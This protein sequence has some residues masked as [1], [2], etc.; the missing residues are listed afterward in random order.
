[1]VEVGGIGTLDQSLVAVS[2]GGTVSFIGVIT[3]TKGEVSMGIA[4]RKAARLQGIFVGS[5]EMLEP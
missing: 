2:P 1:V 4:L 3:G 5:R